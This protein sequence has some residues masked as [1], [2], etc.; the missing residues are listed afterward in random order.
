ME[1]TKESTEKALNLLNIP[2]EKKDIILN[3]EQEK[4]VVELLSV[5][6]VFAILPTGFGKF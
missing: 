1:K 3:E 4:A 2:R 5:K 6:D